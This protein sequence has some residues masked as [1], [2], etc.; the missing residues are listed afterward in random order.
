MTGPGSV[1]DLDELQATVDHVVREAR[2]SEREG[3][4]PESDA[5]AVVAERARFWAPL[6]EDQGRPFERPRRAAGSGAGADVGRGP[7]RVVDVLLDNVFTHTRTTRRC[8]SSLAARDGG[9]LRLTVDDGGP[10][11]PDGVD[12]AGRGESGAGSTGLGLAIVEKTAT[13]SGGGLSWGV[14]PY[15]GARVVVDLGPAG[16]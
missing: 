8:W 15:G 4:V 10:G 3:V 2:R 12:V 9:G 16:G 5:V 14:S 11:F 13:E 7:A 6:A 1:R